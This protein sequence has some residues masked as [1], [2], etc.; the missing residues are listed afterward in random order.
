MKTDVLVLG[1]GVAGLAAAREFQRRGVAVTVLE[2]RD[3]LGG[4]VHTVRD[5]SWPHPI[6]LGAEFGHGLPRR[7]HSP[8]RLRLK[9]GDGEH[10]A[11][12]DGRRTR[13]DGTFEEAME[14]LGQMKGH[15]TTAEKFLT[16]PPTASWAASR[17]P[18]SRASTRPIPAR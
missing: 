11:F 12:V 2:A 16:T 15:E 5:A 7:L 14:L 8:W 9:D 18:S 3:R 1:A 6:E 13:A 4:R 17:A 10:W